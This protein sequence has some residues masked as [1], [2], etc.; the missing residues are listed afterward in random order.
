MPMEKIFSSNSTILGLWVQCC[1]LSTN[2]A[3]L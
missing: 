2:P 3:T 1:M